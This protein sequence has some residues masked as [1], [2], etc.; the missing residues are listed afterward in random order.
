MS[1][2]ERPSGRRGPGTKR[3]RSLLPRVSLMLMAAGW[4]LA[5]SGA[6]AAGP[7][8]VVLPTTGVV[9][10]SMAKYLEDSIAQAE[11]QGVAAVVVKLDTPG[12]DL[13]STNEIVGTLLEAKVPI[14]VWVA[15]AGGF[16]ASAGTFITL[17]AN[18]ALMAPGTSIGAASPISGDGTDI[19]GTLGKKVLNDA[20][21]KITEIATV[22][23]RNVD[24]AVST[25]R[26]A[27]SSPASE[28]VQLGAVD[29]LAATLDEVLAFANG[30]TVDVAGAP[31]TLNLSGATTTEQS[32][33]VFLAFIRLLSD[34][35]IAAVLFA[36]G[37]AGLIA[38]LWSPNFVTGILGALMIILALIGLGSLPLN[39]GGLVLIVFGLVLFG[40][41]VT[42]TSHGLLGVGGLVCVALGLSA[43][44]SGP[45]DPF[46]PFVRVAP[47][48][49]LVIIA[50]GGAFLALIVFGA[51]RSRR[52]GLVPAGMYVANGATGEVRSPLS[53]IGSVIAAGEE[54]SAKTA[55]GRSLDRGTHVR[56]IKVEGL[57]LTV[58]PDASSSKG[59]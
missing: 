34:P 21:A 18:I 1:T 47:P 59:T 40:L 28:A 24:W 38:E 2:G 57:T 52:V 54:W 27:R 53:P 11:Q 42:V 19:G 4:L 46:E 33:N 58:E 48:V 32:M 31:V 44:F 22:R 3:R 25:V 7:E 39:V 43:L 17:S 36:T 9:D 6:E 26:D 10:Q 50:T 49:I 30:K 41:E 8:V 29:G 14:I 37:S 35:T 23:H 13:I 12:G 16:A 15:P 20:I 56:V 51:V 5:A 55:D 45:V